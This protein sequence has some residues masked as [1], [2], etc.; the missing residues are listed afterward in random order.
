[1]DY[2]NNSF[3]KEYKRNRFTKV[4]R[5][6]HKCQETILFDPENMDKV[7]TNI[8]KNPR[9]KLPWYDDELL[10]AIKGVRAYLESKCQVPA[11]RFVNIGM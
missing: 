6:L 5:I 2:L 4:E 10:K 8:E 1:M 3:L 7:R 9:F 11:H